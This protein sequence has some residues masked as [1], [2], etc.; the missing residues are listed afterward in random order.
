MIRVALARA[1]YGKFDTYILDDVLSALDATTEAVVFSALFGSQGL[2]QGKSVIMATNQVYRLPQASHISYLEDGR[3]AEQGTYDELFKRDG[4]LTALVNEFSTGEK[5]EA[6]KVED[7][8]PVA[9]A[10][11]EP[12]EDTKSE[13]T[14]EGELSAKG[15]V[16][17][18]TYGLYLKGMGTTHAVICTYRDLLGGTC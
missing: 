2:L 17:W 5:E 18:S 15:G 1:V 3:I 16:A 14:E 12:A 7:A 6:H 9:D 10:L 11:T 4:L 13:K 8:P